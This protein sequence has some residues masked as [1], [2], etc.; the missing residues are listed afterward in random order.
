M[1]KV[2]YNR[3]ENDKI[4]MTQDMLTDI[5]TYTKGQDK[6]IK[7]LKEEYIILQNA[8]DEVEEELKQRINKAIKYVEEHRNIIERDGFS[9]H[10]LVDDFDDQEIMDILKGVN[11]NG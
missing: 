1:I 7:R 2:Y 6:Y 4:E 3:L 8:S 10:L 11:I 9:L 5:L